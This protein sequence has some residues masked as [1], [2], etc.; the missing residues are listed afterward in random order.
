MKSNIVLA[1]REFIRI[2]KC[3]CRTLA[4]M[5]PTLTANCGNVKVSFFTEIKRDIITNSIGE[6][7][8]SGLRKWEWRE[9]SLTSC[10]KV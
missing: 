10:E 9:A 8:Q 4:L 3:S 1:T 5:S 2:S 7:R 6:T